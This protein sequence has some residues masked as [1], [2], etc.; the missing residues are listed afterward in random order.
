LRNLDKNKL[1]KVISKSKQI[2]EFLPNL[3]IYEGELSVNTDPLYLTIALILEARQKV[4]L[5]PIWPEE[6]DLMVF[7]SKISRDKKQ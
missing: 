6:L 1:R 4:K 2:C 5:T 7:G 3:V